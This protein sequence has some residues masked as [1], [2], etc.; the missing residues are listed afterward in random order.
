MPRPPVL[1]AAYVVL[2]V[3]HVA[4]RAAEASALTV[5]TKPLLMPVLAA[6]LVASSPRPFTRM[7][8]LVLG[9]L[10]FSWLGDILLEVWRDADSDTW[11]L[12]GLGSFLVAQVLYIVAFTP[13]I[14]ART[15]PRPPV[16]ALLYVPVVA[17][18][19]AVLARDLGDLLLPSAVYAAALCLMAVVASG[20]N[21]WTATGAAAF[22]LSDAVLGAGDVA[23]VLTWDDAWRGVLVMSTYLLAQGLLVYGVVRVQREI[24]H[25]TADQ[26]PS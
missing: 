26:A 21:R 25:D 12:A 10:T 16:W 15:P 23:E 13:L 4:G 14:R 3:V 7:V 5:A 1:L 2:S 8:R 9:A 24:W 18:V 20:V 19:V 22:L 17:V 6:Y 11:L